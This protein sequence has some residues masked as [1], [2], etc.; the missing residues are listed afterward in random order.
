MDRKVR[1]WRGWIDVPLNEDGI[2]Q[3]TGLYWTLGRLDRIYTDPLS[4]CRRTAEI[5]DPEQIEVT[6]ES[7]PWNMGS[8]F[9][10]E[11]ITEESLDLCRYYVRRLDVPPPYG[12]TFREWYEPW[13]DWINCL[14][15]GYA[16]VGIV[17]HNRNI[18]ALYATHDG[19]F[20]PHLYDVVGPD[21]CTVHVYDRGQIEPWGGKDVPRGIYLIRHGETDFGT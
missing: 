1:R 17:T 8:S 2:S 14:K 10:G 21:Y 18:Q 12:D 3:A 6:N 11:E 13:V 19:I 16:A 5:L 15:V 20:Y 9:E 4:R 7:G